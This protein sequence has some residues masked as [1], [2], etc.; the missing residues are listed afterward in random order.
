[1]DKIVY[2]SYFILIGILFWGVKIYGRAT[3]ND[4]FMSLSQTKALQGFSAICIMFHHMAQKTCA[5]WLEPKYIIHGLDVFEPI[6]YFFVGIFL[7]C[8]GYGLYKSYQ[9]KTNYLNGFFSRRILPIIVAFYVTACIFLIV[10]M[11]IGEKMNLPQLIYYITGLQLSNGNAWF[12]VTLP[13]FYFIFYM[14]FK[15]CK[16]EKV[17]LS[18]VCIST[19]VY[20]FIG[21]MQDHG[22]WWLGG[23]WWYNTV[24][25]FALGLIFARYEHAVIN[26]VKK[27]Y[28]VYIIGAFITMIAFY[29]F[30]KYALE[31]FSY[32]GEYFDPNFKVL[33][34]WGCLIAQIVATCAFI[35]FVFM[36]GMK[37]KIGN[38]V[39]AFMGTITLECYLIHGLFIELFGYSFFD[40]L[41]SVY[42]IRNVALFVVVVVMLTIPSAILLKK[43]DKWVVSLLTR[44]KATGNCNIHEKA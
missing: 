29:I 9:K 42:Y 10:R 12:A 30:S 32:Y 39:L 34:R 40:I 6:G 18:A 3:W 7:F 1:M 13:I 20:M 44:K 5:S 37:I 38:K 17:A 22:P 15:Y 36:L 16:N 33:R 27:H 35:C 43:F 21:T 24:P 23:E 25:I 11:L 19:F 26:R 8:S 41:P 2:L 28:A 14:A 31:N 4:E